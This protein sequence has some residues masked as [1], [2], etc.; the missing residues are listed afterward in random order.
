M[1]DLLHIVE[2]DCLGFFMHKFYGLEFQVPEIDRVVGG[3][4]P[5]I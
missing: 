5:L 2:S 4:Y 3:C 1:G